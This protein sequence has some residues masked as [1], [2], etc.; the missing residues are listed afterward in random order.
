DGTYSAQVPAG[1]NQNR[2]LIRYKVTAGDALGASV[3]APY[4]DDPQ[5]NFAYYV[6]NGVPGWTG[7]VQPGVTSP[8]TFG[9]EVMGSAPVYT[10][11]TTKQDH[12]NA[13]HVPIGTVNPQ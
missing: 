3:T 10:F 4:A 12:A 1:A 2:T 9:P 7:A 5:L 6:Y 13:L 8:T 11:L